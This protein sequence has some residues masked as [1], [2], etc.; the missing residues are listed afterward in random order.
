MAT[1]TIIHHV[2]GVKTEVRVHTQFIVVQTTV[3]SALDIGEDDEVITRDRFT[4][5]IDGIQNADGDHDVTDEQ[6][7]LVC[8]QFGVHPDEVQDKRD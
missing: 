3:K 4:L 8:T 7:T 1:E 6:V 5:Y 2:R